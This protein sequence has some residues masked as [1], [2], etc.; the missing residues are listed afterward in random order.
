ML[1]QRHRLRLSRDFTQVYRFGRKAVSSH[2]VVRVFKPQEQAQPDSAEPFLWPPQP[3]T[4][5][6]VGITVSQKVHRRA[7]VRNRLKR[8][9]RAIM[10]T[11]IPALPAG[12]WVVVSLRPGADQCE[13]GEFLQELKQ[14]LIQLEV[15]HGHS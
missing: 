9:I 13:Y 14:L 3:L 2:M 4:P 6:K 7:V 12:L 15:L 10:A 8:Q 1:P 11:L 5:V